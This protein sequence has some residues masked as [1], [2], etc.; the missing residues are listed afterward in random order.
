MPIEC[1]HVP[2]VCIPSLTD[3]EKA[4]VQ[5]KMGYMQVREWLHALSRD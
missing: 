4:Q 1:L 3:L 2:L 5:V